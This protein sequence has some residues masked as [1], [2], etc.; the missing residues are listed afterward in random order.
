MDPRDL[1]YFKSI[2][3]SYL[4]VIY[5]DN[6]SY[7]NNRNYIRFALDIQSIYQTDINNF[8]DPDFQYIDMEEQ[9]LYKIIPEIYKNFN[10]IFLCLP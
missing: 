8:L 6:V 9:D 2:S 10:D 1:V 4:I 7:R 3:A 5:S